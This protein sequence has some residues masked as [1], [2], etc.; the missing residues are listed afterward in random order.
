MHSVVV[1]EKKVSASIVVFFVFEVVGAVTDTPKDIGGVGHFP[2]SLRA[3]CV[4]MPAGFSALFD[5]LM[6][7]ECQRVSEHG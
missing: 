4:S 1:C 5:H 3:V 6:I 7:V 2:H